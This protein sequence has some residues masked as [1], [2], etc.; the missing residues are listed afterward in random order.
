MFN[1]LVVFMVKRLVNFMN[2]WPANC[3]FELSSSELFGL[4]WYMSCRD[5]C[6][7]GTVDLAVSLSF[8]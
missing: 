8:S 5:H 3:S 4:P 2:S 6:R 7:S 1:C